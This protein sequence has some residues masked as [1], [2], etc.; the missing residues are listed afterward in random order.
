MLTAWTLGAEGRSAWQFFVGN[1]GSRI[2]SSS[3]KQQH[4][5]SGNS[6]DQDARD[7]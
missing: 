6:W 7:Y 3:V 4:T 5:I 1:G 2:R